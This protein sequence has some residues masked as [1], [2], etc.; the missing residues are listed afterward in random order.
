MINMVYQLDS[1]YSN[2]NGEIFI[3]NDKTKELLY[4]VNKH[5]K[6]G[7]FSTFKIS[8]YPGNY[9]YAW[10][11][12]FAIDS[13]AGASWMG[14]GATHQDIAE[15]RIVEFETVV[16]PIPQFDVNNPKMISQGPSLCIF[17]KEDPQEV[18]ASWIFM[19][20]M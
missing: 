12:I 8:S 6:T 14:S 20:Y 10:Q 2:D 16:R 7:A 1:G 17:N 18:L 19:Q 9:L 11:C 5:A 13:T 15:D 3:F 4:E